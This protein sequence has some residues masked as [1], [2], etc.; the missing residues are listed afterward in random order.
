[1]RSAAL[2]G[3][4]LVMGAGLGA[5]AGWAEARPKL[6][7]DG[8]P[9]TIGRFR[10]RTFPKGAQAWIDGELKV[11][12]T[13]ATLILEE[14]EY[15]LVIRAPGA[16]AVERTIVVEAGE[17]KSLSMRIPPSPPATVSVVSDVEGAEVRINGYKRGETPLLSAE[18]APGPVDVTVTEPGG[19]ARSVKLEL[20]IGQREWIEAF[21]GDVASKPEPAPPNPLQCHP[22]AVGF[23]SIGLKPEGLIETADGDR[24]GE[25]PLFDKEMEAGAYDL[26]L[27]S[28]DGKYE[29]RV[30]IEIAPDERAVYRFMFRQEDA[31]R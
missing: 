6:D 19:R 15:H 23:L 24:I 31:V 29:K 28:K 26:R 9:V 3:L 2:I 5:L 12:S 27:I 1:M 20:G 22:R 25:S 13:P 7:K 11:L 21:F 16:E 30:S 18:T 4:G 8:R 14:G 10:L 17:S